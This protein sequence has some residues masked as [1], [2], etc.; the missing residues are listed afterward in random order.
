M[1][2]LD[3]PQCGFIISLI[4]IEGLVSEGW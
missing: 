4:P 1:L 3:F 2:A